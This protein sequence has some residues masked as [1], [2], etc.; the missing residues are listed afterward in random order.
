M[1]LVKQSHIIRPTPPMGEDGRGDE[2]DVVHLEEFGAQGVQ[3]SWSELHELL[4]NREADFKPTL[5]A[6]GGA[7]RFPLGREGA[8]ACVR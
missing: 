6:A 4:L 3:V 5:F 7:A 2:D 1:A 8:R